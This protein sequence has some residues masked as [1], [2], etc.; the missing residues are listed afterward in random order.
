[1]RRRDLLAMFISASA[2]P[3][4]PVARAER[5]LSVIVPDLPGGAAGTEMRVLQPYLEQALARPVV[6]DFRPGAGG[7]IGLMAGAQAAA[8]GT[9][10][11]LLTPAVTLA[12]WLSRRMDCTPADFAPL[13][14]ISFTPVVLAVRADA[15][16]ADLAGLLARRAARETVAVPAPS[17][18]DAS[19]VAQ[20][21]F[22]A[23]AEL[24]VRFVSGLNTPAERLAALLA[25][26]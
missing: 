21:L 4:L 3:A 14:R 23:R 2:A 18:W 19:Q 25:G 10:L 8:D 16:Y 26:D 7:I 12:P 9:T 6:L 22:L 1:M 15:P 13:G 24:S 5:A 20:A 17:E 11:T